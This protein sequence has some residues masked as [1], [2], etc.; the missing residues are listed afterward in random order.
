M[1]TIHPPHLAWVL[2]SATPYH[3]ARAEAAR[4]AGLKLTMVELCGR[5]AFAPTPIAPGE[6]RL[7][8]FP[9]MSLAQV[10]RRELPRRL[11][12]AL[13]ALAP[14]V[15]AINGWSEGG[16]I[17]S[18][19]WALKHKVPTVIF[20]E[21]SAHDEPRVWWKE[22]VKRRVL[23]LCSAYQVGGS[24]HDAYVRQLLG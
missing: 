2:V 16:A 6:R 24:P 14:D 23:R 18:L 9:S 8:L 3:L 17:A 1:N 20:S 19:S 7:T 22:W 13:D 21:S 4:T 15:V 11:R 5:D 10:P 12:A